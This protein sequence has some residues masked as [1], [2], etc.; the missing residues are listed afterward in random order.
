MIWDS[1][2]ELPFNGLYIL[3]GA[4]AWI[5]ALGLVQEGLEELRSRQSA[6]KAA[7]LSRER[8]PLTSSPSVTA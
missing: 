3:L 8:S 1:P 6:A 2:L 4:V 5:I 7:T